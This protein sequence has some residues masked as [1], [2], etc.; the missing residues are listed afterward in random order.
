MG[1]MGNVVKKK[2]EVNVSTGLQLQR[3]PL[4]L[5]Y[6]ALFAIAPFL[7]LPLLFTLP[8]VVC[9]NRLA[10]GALFRNGFS[11]MMYYISSSIKTLYIVL[12]ALCP[13]SLVCWSAGFLWTSSS[14]GDSEKC[15][16]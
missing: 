8:A 9:M 11:T 7:Y 12:S 4:E 2:E 3:L 14:R 5:V 6:V 1:L 15:G 13:I 16:G 10:G